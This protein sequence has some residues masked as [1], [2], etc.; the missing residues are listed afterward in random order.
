[1]LRV[2]D[3][4]IGIEAARQ[5]EVFHEFV[6]LH[7]P[8]RDRQQGL[9]LG[10]A[11]V[12]RLAELLGVQVSLR[13]RL[14]SGSTFTLRLDAVPAPA[15]PLAEPAAVPL[16][17]QAGHAGLV[18]VIDDDADLRDEFND[19]VPAI[20]ITGDT[21]P[22]RLREAAAGGHVLLHKPVSPQQLREYM[23]GASAAASR[24]DA[25]A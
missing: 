14:G 7:N 16:P 23:A 5:E 22:E 24:A 25:A 6:Q 9:G 10:L 20:V 13:S 12:R 15:V 11:I 3:T 21:A 4:G 17:G 19:D 8:E 2:V 1:V 18:L